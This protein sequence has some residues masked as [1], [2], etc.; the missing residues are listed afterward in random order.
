MIGVGEGV[1][2]GVATSFISNLLGPTICSF[3]AL[4]IV[5]EGVGEGV[6]EGETD[7]DAD[8]E[9]DGKTTA[10]ALAPTIGVADAVA[11]ITVGDGEVSLGWT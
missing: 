9:A 4:D 5:G 8:A 3:P 1:G 11:T 10:V 6:D 7:G 2:V